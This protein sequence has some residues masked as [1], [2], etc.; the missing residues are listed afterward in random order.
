MI[1]PTAFIHKTAIVENDHIG[2]RTRIYAF[3]HILQGARIGAD[4]NIND[5]CFIEGDVVLGDRVTVK[6]GNYL[7]DGLRVEDD[8][9]LGPN[10]VYTND[11]TPRSKRYPEKFE[12]ILIEKGASI[13]ANSV[14]K[15]GI[16]IGRYAMVGMGSVVTEDVPSHALVYGNPAR[17]HGY[18]CRCGEKLAPRESSGKEIY[19]CGC[20]ESYYLDSD[21]NLIAADRPSGGKGR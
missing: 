16:T 20:G 21:N 5:H 2:A 17:M 13:G 19:E 15:G 12:Q 11:I 6:C 8:A 9:F 1:D 7:W 10:V 14:L 3:V 4:C 18:V